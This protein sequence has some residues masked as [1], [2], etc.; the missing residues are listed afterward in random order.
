MRTDIRMLFEFPVPESNVRM[1]ASP[2]EDKNEHLFQDHLLSRA[3][4]LQGRKSHTLAVLRPGQLILHSLNRSLTLTQSQ[5]LASLARLTHE[6]HF[7][8]RKHDQT[9]LLIP[10]GLVLGITT[11]ASARDFEV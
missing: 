7:D 10:G 2:V 11:S 9:E 6:K 1:P 3:D 4:V 5:Q 8:C